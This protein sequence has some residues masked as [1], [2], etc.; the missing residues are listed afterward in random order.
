MDSNKNKV[1]NRFLEDLSPFQSNDNLV[2]TTSNVSKNVT[3]KYLK[4]I[5]VY[6]FFSPNKKSTLTFNPTGADTSKNSKRRFRYFHYQNY[7]TFTRKL[8]F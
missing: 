1:C 8:K 4:H 6:H 7:N 5:Y 3:N 2:V